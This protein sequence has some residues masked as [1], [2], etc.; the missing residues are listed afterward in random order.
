[1]LLSKSCEYGMRAVLFIAFAKED[2][3][4]PIKEISDELGIPHHFLTKILQKLTAAELL[5]SMKGPN[6]GVQLKKDSKNIQLLEIVKAIDGSELF[7]ECVLGLPDCGDAKPCALHAK[8]MDR[9]EDIKKMLGSTTLKEL[10]K[11][12]KQRSSGWDLTKVW[13]DKEIFRQQ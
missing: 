1:M 13:T 4:I 8:W 11:K 3:Y 5:K 6:G 10:A 2:N 9:R 12:I 7:T